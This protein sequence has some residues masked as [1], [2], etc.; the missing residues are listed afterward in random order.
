MDTSKIA[1]LLSQT[2]LIKSLNTLLEGEQVE[3]MAK[4]SRFIIRKTSRLTGKSFLSVN[5]CDFGTQKADMSLVEKSEFLLE[6]YGIRISKQSLDERYNS[7]AVKF[8]FLC[9]K[10]LFADYL[11]GFKGL[12]GIEST[13][14][15]INLSDSTSF[16]LKKNLSAFYL[17]NGGDNSG[18]SIKIQMEYELLKSQ[19][20]DFSIGNGTDADASFL[21]KSASFIKENSLNIKDLGYFRLSHFEK[22][23][24]EKAYFRISA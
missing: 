2:D 8:M 18:S 3:K 6:Q 23:I 10:K 12:K 14:S 15:A 19:I 5:I 22:I 16:S 24:A 1:D 9:F 13:F 7:Y 21:E 20:L 17:G 4:E 11:E